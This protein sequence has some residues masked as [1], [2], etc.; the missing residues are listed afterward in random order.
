MPVLTA[1][2]GNGENIIKLDCEFEC[3][4][5]YTGEYFHFVGGSG[6]NYAQR[7]AAA[8]VDVVPV[9]PVGEDA[10]G[11]KI[12]EMI[13]RHLVQ[14][15]QDHGFGKVYVSSDQFFMDGVTTSFSTIIID[16]N[17]TRTCFSQ[18]EPSPVNYQ[19]HVRDALS[20]LEKENQPVSALIIGHIH[21]DSRQQNPDNPGETT[22]YLIDR[23]AGKS[24]VCANFG[25][26]QISL[27]INFWEPYLDKIDVFQLNLPEMQRFFT[28]S[29]HRADPLDLIHWFMEK[30]ITAIITLDKKG[31][32]GIHNNGKPSLVWAPGNALPGFKDST[33]AGDAFMSG[34]VSE[35]R[36]H[37]EISLDKFARAMQTGQK[38]AEYACGS[39]GASSDCPTRERLAEAD[40][41][42][43]EILPLDRAGSLLNHMFY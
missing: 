22:K 12:R 7:L 38:W 20:F 25:T 24:L 29:G 34:L 21:S 8:G 1:G 42:K 13:L 10:I 19:A 3:N 28:G 18:Q 33:G 27:G 40:T 4:Q 30:R 26:S 35:L 23:F 39:L 9:L 31:A 37:R 17:Q 16:K 41:S 32:L 36:D 5:K 14:G 2:S 15:N 43:V 6:V 11:K